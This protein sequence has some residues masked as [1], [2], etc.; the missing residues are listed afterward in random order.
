MTDLRERLQG[1]QTFPSLV[2]FLREELDWPIDST[3][4]FEELTF[5]Y[6]P[7]E[8]GIEP[9]SAAKIDEIK[10]LRPLSS[11]QPWGIF[12]VKFEP[13]HLPVV[14]LRRILNRV[15]V[16]KQATP[17]AAEQK[18]WATDDLLFISAYGGDDERRISFAHFSRDS[19]TS[20]LPTLKVLAWDDQDTGLH[21]DDVADRLVEYLS[22]PTPDREWDDETWRER[23]RSAFALR[24]G[25][26][27][28]TSKALATRLAELARAIRIRIRGV[29]EIESEDGPVTALMDAFR[30][31]LV[32]DLEPDDFADMYAQ[33]IAYGLLSARIADPH[34]DTV[35]DLTVHM[36]TNPFLRELMQTFIHVGGPRGSSGGTAI[37]FDELGVSEVVNLL[38]HANMEAVVLDFGDKNPR[39]DPVIHF[40]ELFLKEYDA[41]KRMQRGVFYTPRPVVSFI[42]RAVDEALRCQLGLADGLADT[43]TWGEMTARVPGLTIPT[44]VQQD[45]PFVQV[46]DPATGTGTFLV[47]I[48]DCIHRRMVDKW[49]AAGHDE[50]EVRDL[51][52]HYVPRYLLP[53]LHG[54]ELLM[55]PYAIAHLKIRLKLL[56]T[57]YRFASDERARIYLTNTLEP[58]HDFSDR[59]EF[60][61]PALAHEATAVNEIKRSKRFTVITGNPPYAQYSMNLEDAARAHIDKFRFANG[62]KLR[63]RNALQLERNLNDDYVK[64]LGASSDLLAE[65]GIIAM[66]TNRMYLE[67]ES[68]V[69]VREWFARHFDRIYVADL[70]GSSEESRRVARLA[71]DENV[72][73]I[74]QGV[75]VSVF[76]R[77][78]LNGREVARSFSREVVGTRDAKYEL[79]ADGLTLEDGSWSEGGPSA[80]QW[81]LHRVAGEDTAESR[82]LTL[83]EA[84]REFSTLVSS[85]RDSIVVGFDMDTV[86][87]TVERIRSFQGTNEEWAQEFGITL[88]T[89]WN[90]TAARQKLSELV[91]LSEF[92][93]QIEYRPFDRRW[94]FFHPTLVWQTAPVTSQNVLHRR[95]N[96]VLLSLGKNR[97]ETTNGQ[98][99]SAILADKSVVSTRDNASGFPLYTYPPADGLLGSD[100]HRSH[101]LS[102][103]FLKELAL[104]LGLGETRGDALP[105][106]IDAEEIFYC[107]Y[108]LLYSP[109]YRERYDAFLKADFPRIPL[110]ATL[111]L[112]RRLSA[113]GHELTDLHLMKTATASQL[114]VSYSGPS[115][116]V[117]ENVVW[118]TEIV[119]LDAAATKKRESA[120]PGTIGFRGVPEAVWNFHIGG[121]QVCE[122]WLKDRKGRTLSE[123]DIAHYQKVVVAI[124]ETL[125]LMEDIDKVIVGHGGWPDAFGTPETEA[126]A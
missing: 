60:A 45:E 24:H 31:A 91:D 6:T 3:D 124:G 82:Q 74:L 43:A 114:T 33:T 37:D 111:A 48:I 116:P 68:L 86:L 47:E 55:A 88:K 85:N 19:T 46:L 117:V 118:I 26:V 32:H 51:W 80:R 25:E 23:W 49:R 89:G 97:A 123:D 100:G 99:V 66:I 71:D 73:D 34:A 56:E 7:E 67:S 35:D 58:P 11:N 30:K 92:M 75:A 29:L 119:W 106:G 27:V 125:R 15:V 1:I 76:V 44:G 2:K 36:R 14:A 22:W 40:Y 81:Y 17:S 64:F 18:K 103:V 105:D 72:F 21:L 79:L 90:V 9:A 94:I 104:A 12:F 84:F 109:S 61:V 78:G 8:L 57:G 16:K 83:A 41:T 50:P 112:F 69:G 87:A 63:A 98:W 39:E 54:Y 28:T 62:E 108:A 93:E 102:P 20:E 4:D 38:D 59:L 95:D 77:E 52:N 10:R 120:T 96:L 65:R 42:V 126:A 101:N 13:K 70:W 115:Q 107:M 5:D 53:R 110:P 113:L 121:Y 122:K